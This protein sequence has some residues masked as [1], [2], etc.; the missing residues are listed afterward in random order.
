MFVHEKI[1][2]I[3]DD[4]VFVFQLINVNLNRLT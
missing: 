4:Q 1:F 2:I 3:F